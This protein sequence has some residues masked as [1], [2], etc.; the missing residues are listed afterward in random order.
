MRDACLRR[1]FLWVEIAIF[2]F[3]SFMQLLLN[4]V[5]NFGINYRLQLMKR[6]AQIR[7]ARKEAWVQMTLTFS[8]PSEGALAEEGA[9][10]HG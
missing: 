7:A 4:G 8:S 3:I 5:D 9:E 1:C 10:K 6:V 2:V